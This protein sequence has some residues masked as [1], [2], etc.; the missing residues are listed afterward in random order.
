MELGSWLHV[1]LK[2]TYFFN[3]IHVLVNDMASLFVLL[4]S[5]I[6]GCSRLRDAVVRAVVILTLRV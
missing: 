2:I 3:N 6:S 1:S 5:T 4:I